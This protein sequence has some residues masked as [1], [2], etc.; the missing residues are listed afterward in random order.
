M[1]HLIKN[2]SV[3]HLLM[4]MCHVLIVTRAADRKEGMGGG[5]IGAFCSGPHL[6]WDPNYIIK[7]RSKCSN[8]TATLIK[9]LGRYSVDNYAVMNC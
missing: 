9:Q 1:Q 3:K 2:V 6:A 8:R 4:I 7:K 5:K